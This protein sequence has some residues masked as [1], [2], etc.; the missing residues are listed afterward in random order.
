M[1]MRELK[2]KKLKYVVGLVFMLSACQQNPLPKDG[3]VQLTPA[4][5][6]SVGPAFF[7]ATP[8]FFDFQEG[9]EATYLLDVAAGDE[10]NLIL[11]SRNLPPGAVFS[12]KERRLTW[13][14]S[15]DTGTH[16]NLPQPKQY[17]VHFILRNGANSVEA[18]DK[19][20][21]LI[22]KDM[23]QEIKMAVSTK[24]FSMLEGSLFS[25]TTKITSDDYP[26]GPF[27][28]KAMGELS[29]IQ[30]TSVNA[31]KTEFKIQY[32]P[33]AST[34]DSKS[35]TAYKNVQLA[36]VAPDG[37]ELLVDQSWT[38]KNVT[39]PPIVSAPSQLTANEVATW[40]VTAEDPNAEG[41]PT[42]VLPKVPFGKLT[43]Q[44]QLLPGGSGKNPTVVYNLLWTQIPV[45][46]RDKTF[47]LDYQVCSG[48]YSWQKICANQALSVKLSA[49]SSK[50]P[51]IDRKAWP[52]G[53]TKYV[54]EGST[55][56]FA[57]PVTDGNGSSDVPSVTVISSSSDIITYSKG[58][59][60]VQAKAPKLSQVSLTA[61][62]AFGE[63]QVESFL[64][65]VLPRTW[66]DTLIIGDH[67]KDPEIDSIYKFSEQVQFLNPSLQ[68]IDDRTLAFRKRMI[69]TTSALNDPE[70][71]GGIE[72]LASRI[73]NVLII[74]PLV[75]EL[76]GSLRLEFNSLKIETPS[77]V[78][79][80]SAGRVPPVL[81]NLSLKVVSSGMSGL[82]TAPN[83]PVKFKGSLT[84]ESN[85]PA[86]V[87]VSAGLWGSSSCKNV[88]AYFDATTA[89]QWPAAVECK[90][91]N[92][93]MILVSGTEFGDFNFASS[94]EGWIASW[95]KN[96]GKK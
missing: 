73:Q 51:V 82:I 56:I 31:D 26:N 72:F 70:Q 22:V 14:P 27:V 43:S 86:I 80:A 21:Y 8:P 49:L 66:A 44:E 74:S 55:S 78:T 91:A 76:K 75:V 90:R 4:P 61:T 47:T 11:E 87:Q 2:H 3:I 59:L 39:F 12:A 35:G 77:R 46:Q 81:G 93:G 20:V 88:L 67:K 85:A 9:V 68:G 33:Q 32:L 54:L 69:V 94:D 34:V 5:H 36:A 30:V 10:K 24:N 15:F 60:T 58:M 92:G 57:V 17:E 95:F 96:W 28:L 79:S 89:S 52:L 84:R 48:N 38:V 23:P 62:S 1:R 83:A 45:S 64:L 19:T 53:Q 63:K 16:G 65:E 40:T 13:K 25:F 18:I 41:K 42:I 37:R 71:W 7:L 50:P 6:R 29:G